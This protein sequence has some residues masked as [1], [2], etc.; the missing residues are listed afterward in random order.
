[1]QFELSKVLQLQQ[2]GPVCKKLHQASKKLVSVLA[3]FAP[4]TEASQENVVVLNW[5][6]CICYL[7]WFKKSKVQ[8]Q[9]LINFGSEVNAM[10]LGYA[11]KLDLK[12]RSTNI[13]M[14]KIDGSTLEMFKMVLA[15]FQVEDKLRR[16]RF[17]QKTFLLADFSVE[18]V[19][20]MPFLTFSNANI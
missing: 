10:T 17:F 11:S 16:P 12:V 9:A 14:Q 13:G 6:P 18:V 20:G 7:I 19:L 2:K 15:S 3:T 4:V 8:V 5:V 1:M